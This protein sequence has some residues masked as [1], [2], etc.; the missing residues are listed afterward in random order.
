MAHA[1]GALN[2]SCGGPQKAI[3]HS[4]VSS[5]VTQV[6]IPHLTARTRR[7]GLRHRH[8]GR[9]WQSGLRTRQWQLVSLVPPLRAYQR[10]RRAQW[11]PSW[12]GRSW[13]HQGE[14]NP[15]RFSRGLT[16]GPLGSIPAGGVLSRLHHAD[17]RKLIIITKLSLLLL[18]VLRLE[19]RV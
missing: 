9:T 15:P 4:P 13:P 6:T 5:S 12:T 11:E 1:K 19:G 7:C 16:Q 17:L 10:Y 8:A 3:P 2:S 14:E 18:S